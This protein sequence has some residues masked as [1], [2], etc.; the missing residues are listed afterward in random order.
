M[1]TIDILQ[2]L[3]FFAALLVVIYHINP[4]A[5]GVTD[6]EGMFRFVQNGGSGVDIFFV[7]SGFIITLT[8]MR[9]ETFYA[10]AF[11]L[12]RFFR[13]YPTYWVFLTLAILLG[14]ISYKLTGSS[15][16]Y[17]L[18]EPTSLLASYFLAPIPVQIYPVAWTLTLE[19]AF[20]F[21]F[22]I[23]Y[24]LGGLPAVIGSLLVW[25]IVARV[26][27]GIIQSPGGGFIWFFHSVVLEFLYGVLIAWLWL[28]ERIKFPIVVFCVGCVAY[29]GVVTGFFEGFAVGRE[30]KWGIPAAI[31]I[32]GAVGIPWKAPRLAVLAGDSSYILYLMHPLLITTAKVLALRLFDINVF[33]SNIAAIVIIVSSVVIS[34][35][36]THWLEAPYIRWYKRLIAKWQG[37]AEVAAGRAP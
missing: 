9:K 11:S 17:E 30:I 4:E 15:G 3:R 21:I 20:Y 13:I 29:V 12:N 7:I 2:F 36:M 35:A 8:V 16:T 37:R 33:E 22:C 27:G 25:Y 10:F 34:M 1:F 19:I 24:R 28:N 5:G 6:F 14:F 26:F 31:L 18:V 32:Y 23:S